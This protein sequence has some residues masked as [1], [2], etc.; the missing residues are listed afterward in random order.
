MPHC[1]PAHGRFIVTT[2]ISLQEAQTK[3]PELIH[4][5]HE[6]AE[7]VI[8][9][10]S[11]PVARLLPAVGAGPRKPPRPGTLRGTVL[12]MAPDFDA[13]LDDFEEYME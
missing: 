13:P 2:R 6:G 8:T 10:D 4:H 12:Y 3:L 5:L 11:Q 1:V 9:E 7:V